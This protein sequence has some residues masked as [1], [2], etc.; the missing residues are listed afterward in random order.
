MNSLRLS[1]ACIDDCVAW[2]GLH[3][4]QNA[5]LKS[6]A[7]TCH[8]NEDHAFFQLAVVTVNLN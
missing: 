6:L 3:D 1:R 8:Y 7:T 5:Q 2:T 4:M